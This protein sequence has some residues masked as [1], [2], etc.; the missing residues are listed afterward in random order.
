ML[1]I[2]FAIESELKNILKSE[3]PATVYL[4]INIQSVNAKHFFCMAHKKNTRVFYEFSVS[5]QVIANVARLIVVAY[6]NDA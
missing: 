5:T 2:K 6:R 4:E 3:K 1:Y